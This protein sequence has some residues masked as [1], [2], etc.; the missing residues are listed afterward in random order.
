[1]T[2]AS[3]VLLFVFISEFV[4]LLQNSF[5]IDGCEFFTVHNLDYSSMFRLTAQC[6]FVL[7]VILS[8]HSIP[9]ATQAETGCLTEV[10][11][12]HIAAVVAHALEPGVH[13]CILGR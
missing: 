5:P 13:G 11:T 10:V 3:F 2:T 7:L 1:M 8:A 4:V 6:A 9:D 12:V